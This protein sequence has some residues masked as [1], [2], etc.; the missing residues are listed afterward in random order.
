MQTTHFVTGAFACLMLSACSGGGGG[1]GAGG[2]GSGGS[3]GLPAAPVNTTLTDLRASQ[4]FANDAAVNSAVFD[5]KTSTGIQGTAGSSN[6]T[7]RYDATA[8]SYTVSTADR[9]QTFGTT[10]VT[11]DDATQTIYKKSAGGANEYLTLVK[12]GYSGLAATRYVRLGYW[13]RNLTADGRQ[14]TDY[15]SFTYGLPTP[16]GTLPRTGTAAY[17]IDTFGM[18]SA[19]GGEPRSI[20]GSGTFSVDLEQNLFTAHSYLQETQLVHSGGTSGGGI[21]FNA[22]G[23]IAAD[24][25]FAGTLGYGG[26]LG[27]A[28]GAL[29]G[30]FYGPNGEELGA[31]FSANNAAGL[32]VAGSFVG[33]RDLTGQAD[34][35]TLTNLTH[36]Q[37]FYTRFGANI[38]GSLTWQNSETFTASSYSSGYSG[39]QFTLADKVA[40]T[41]PNFTTYKKSFTTYYDSQYLQ[42]V[43]L[44]LYKPGTA[45]TEL[46]L[47]YASFGHW[48]TTEVISGSNKPRVDQ[49]FVYGFYTPNAMFAARTGTAEYT[50]VAYGTGSTYTTGEKYAVTGSSKFVVDFSAAK[51]DATLVLAGKAMS[52]GATLNFGSFDFAGKISSYGAT[53]EASFIRD[54]T[55]LGTISANFFGPDASEIAAPFYLNLPAN[56]VAPNTSITGAALAKRR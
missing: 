23:K 29:A 8:N 35:F 44:E 15:V 26:S 20:G 38:G 16:A 10:D 51:L 30:R 49:Y 37:Q 22:G 3:G 21:E 40:S 45:N 7:V 53:G 31:T 6:L 41:D 32:S 13:Q 34:N 54:Q 19:P 5:L 55:T 43:T 25:S 17:K 24:G 2:I 12:A 56:S 42:P 28:G 50:G 46:A 47:T 27:Q 39:G 14:N 1:A 33:A 52:N 9:S 11:T 18:V 36:E 4:S 48:I